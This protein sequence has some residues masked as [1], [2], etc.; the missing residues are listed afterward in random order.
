MSVNSS[1][2]Y[3]KDSPES[4]KIDLLN[5]HIQNTRKEITFN[6]SQEGP[7][8]CPTFVFKA[9]YDGFEFECK[10]T[11]KND[12]KK[13][14]KLE[15]WDHI[16]NTLNKSDSFEKNPNRIPNILPFSDFKNILRQ[17]PL[18]K[19]ILIIDLEN[20]GGVK[21][22]QDANFMSLCR[23]LSCTIICVFARLFPEYYEDIVMIKREDLHRDSADEGI[24]R[25]VY[26]L[27]DCLG[28]QNIEL[29]TSDHFGQTL[30]DSID[31]TG[32]AIL[33]LYLNCDEYKMKKANGMKKNM[34]NMS[35]DLLK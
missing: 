27:V 3:S 6:H 20:A 4:V 22:L 19:P 1:L 8:H 2:D 25:I 9:A 29:V 14:L 32:Q 23:K 17:V 34:K 30:K 16:N 15:I 31:E 24:R 28:A 11:S 5:R 18:D 13:K 12:C 33:G 26:Y 10:G 21:P 7:S 35:Q